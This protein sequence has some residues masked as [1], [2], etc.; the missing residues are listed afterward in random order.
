MVRIFGFVTALVVHAERL[1][2]YKPR[3]PRRKQDG[4]D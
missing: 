4:F 3:V 1:L 2:D